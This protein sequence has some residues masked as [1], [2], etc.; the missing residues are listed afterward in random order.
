MNHQNDMNYQNNMND[1]ADNDYS[2]SICSVLY[3]QFYMFK[4]M[5]KQSIKSMNLLFN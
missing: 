3:A 4:R 5:Q 2:D 1:T